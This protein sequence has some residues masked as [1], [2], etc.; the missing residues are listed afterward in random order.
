MN[1][2]ELLLIKYEQHNYRSKTHQL[3]QIDF[4]PLPKIF[5][6][7][8]HLPTQ[9]HPNLTNIFNII[10]YNSPCSLRVSVGELYKLDKRVVEIY[11][12]FHFILL[13][14]GVFVYS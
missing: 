12:F 11:T 4:R 5:R 6:V 13:L 10:R 3:Q 1:K 7:S 14:I 9:F 8:A 2:Y